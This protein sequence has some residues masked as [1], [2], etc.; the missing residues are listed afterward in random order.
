MSL[1]NFSWFPDFNGSIA[2]LKK[3][4][5]SENWDYIKKPTGYHPILVNYIHHTFNKIQ[6][7][8]KIEYEQEFCC[9]NTGLVTENQEEIYGYS[10]KN[11]KPTATI[12]FYFIGWRKASHRELSKFSKLAEIAT[13]INDPSDLIY[14]IK[15]KLRTNIDHIIQDNKSRFPNPFNAMD[16]HMLSNILNGTIEDAKRRVKRNY[17][18]AIPQFYNGKLQLLLPLC[19]QTKANA[20]LALVIEKKREYTEHQLI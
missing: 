1:F 2:E 19:L 16:N 9:F 3:L 20:D 5:M 17:K 4:A 7:E 15:L 14:D 18:T 12:P 13:Y 8:G 10:Q 6:H 11:K